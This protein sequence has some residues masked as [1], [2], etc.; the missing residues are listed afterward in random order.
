MGRPSTVDRRRVVDDILYVAAAIMAT[1]PAVG[2]E[3]SGQP[4]A[5]SSG[6][7]R[8]QDPDGVRPPRVDEP[9]ADEQFAGQLEREA[10]G[11]SFDETPLG[12]LSIVDVDLLW[13]VRVPLRGGV[14]VTRSL[15]AV[16]L[17]VRARW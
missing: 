3:R 5:T 9:T 8:Q 16:S 10:A 4:A 12:H 17:R 13:T 2:G 6:S 1:H 14:R 11:V 7:A 15:V